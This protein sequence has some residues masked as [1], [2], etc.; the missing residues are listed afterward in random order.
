M[1]KNKKIAMLGLLTAIAFGLS[2]LEFL[3]PFEALVGIPGVKLG[4]ANLAVMAA[5]CLLGVSEAALVSLTRVLLAWLIF[6]N[7]TGFLFSAAGAAL[8]LCVMWLLRKTRLFGTVGVSVA[9]GVCHNLAQLAVASLL[10]DAAAL[11][12]YLPVL[13][14]AGVLTGALNGAL[15]SEILKRIKT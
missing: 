12:Y 13:L 6:G 1:S 10:T 3:I 8:S 11:L 2:Y 9:G 7:F 4:L 14:L 15:L 5:L